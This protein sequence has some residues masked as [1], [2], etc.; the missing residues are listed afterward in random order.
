MKSRLPR[1]DSRCSRRGPFGPRES[2][3]MN[4]IGTNMAL[5][6]GRQGFMRSQAAMERALE[7]LATGKRINRASDD[8]SG[9][10]AADALGARR[11]TLEDMIKRSER[12]SRM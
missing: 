1:T 7:R 9:L 8:P 6:V 11:V 10:L 5:L 3:R 4:G 2:P 12:V